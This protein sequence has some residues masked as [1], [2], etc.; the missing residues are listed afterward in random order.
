MVI[1]GGTCSPGVTSDGA[2]LTVQQAPVIT[3]QPSSQVVCEGS[4]VTYSVSATGTGLTYQWKKG[5]VDIGKRHRGEPVL[6]SVSAADAGS[7]TVLVKGTCNTAGILSSAGTLTVNEQPEV[8]TQPV[9]AVICE[10]GNTSFTVSPGVTT[11]ATYQ[12]QVSMNGG[13]SYVAVSNGGIYAGATS[14]TL[15]LTGAPLTNNDYLYRVV[16]GG[17][18]NPGV[19]SEGARLTVQQA[20]VIAGQPSAQIVCEGSTVTFTVNAVGTGLTY[21]WKKGG[22]DIGSA[23]GASLVLSSVSASDAA[24]YTVLV[25]GT[26]NTT[27]VL[28][29]VATLTVNEQPE[30]TAQPVNSVICEGA[31][32]GFTVGAGVTTGATYQWQVSTNG[33]TGYTN[34]SNGGIYTGVTSATLSLTGAPL[35]N[36]GYLYRVVVG[37]TCSPGVVSDGALL[38]VQQAPVITGQ[39]SAQVV[40]EG[41]T[42]TFT[43]NAVGTGLTYQWKKGGV[44]ISSAT[45]ASLVL[46]SVTAADATGYTV[47]VKGTCN[48]IGVL[49]SVATLTVNEQPEITAQ[50]VNALICEGGNTNFT[51]SAG[52]TTG[53]TY[54]WQVSTN[55]GTSYA[56]VSNGGIY[57]GAT[58]ATLSLTG[59]PLTNNGYLYRV[60]VGGTCSPGVVS[61]GAL[62]TVQQAPVIT[63]QPS[64]QV[65]CEGSTVTFTVN[66]VGTGLTYQWKKGGV[67]ISSATSASLVL[68]SVTAADA[69][70]YT[71]L[72][73]GACNATGVLSSVASLTVN[74]QPEI[75]AQPVNALI[76]EGGNTNFTVSAGV[77]T[78]ATYQWQVSTSGGTSYATVS[79]GGI[80]AGATSA[81]LS[82]TGAPLTNNGY[83]YRV[84]VGGTCAP[85]VI[86]EGALLTVQ[87]APVITGQ[88]SAQVVCEG[89][90]VTFTVNAVGTGLTYQWKKSGVDI[91]G[92]TSATLV[93]SSVSAADAASYTVLVKGC[94]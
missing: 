39:P 68:S 71:V 4:T 36:N 20:P 51:V 37:G 81:T 83:L 40:C 77:T 67:D 38:T 8:T 29:S 41:S 25:K 94:L 76:C 21:Q 63:G 72:V 10:G 18:C 9:N 70:G 6:S 52:V 53:A 17:T 28:S 60:V 59:A 47:L 34:I 26:C 65:V 14:A 75:T 43:V 88:P 50:P 33:G 84:V 1:V 64:A 7:Y 69:A 13:T 23:T 91:G 55:G 86:S 3:G 80:Y 56:T 24:G 58:S 85:N 30:I 46:S 90:T 73:K 48:A 92:A 54:Q 74:E 78:G 66:A 22:V 82:L 27:G 87:Q 61:D 12:W 5:G 93:L 49:S 45:S 42:V 31:N 57:A 19:I 11:G 44:D 62:L 35:T 89:S 32:T 16:V 2:L 15:S 79:N